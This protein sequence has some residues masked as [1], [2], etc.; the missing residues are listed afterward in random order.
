MNTE[1]IQ[2]AQFISSIVTPIIILLLGLKINKTLEANKA[3]LAKDKEWRTEWA[4]RFY[5]AAIEFNSAVDDCIITLFIIA[6]LS[7]EKL[8][9]WEKRFKDKEDSIPAMF[10]RLQRAEWVLKTTADLAPNS[11]EEILTHIS[12]VW[13]TLSELYKRKEGNL[14]IIRRYL[15][16]FNKA[17]M[18]AHREILGK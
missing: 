17:A 2:I 15:L 6:Q 1:L 10:E 13:S 8:P 12:K 3:S 5:S 9:E 16:D 18:I 11:K 14:E 4:K 7:K